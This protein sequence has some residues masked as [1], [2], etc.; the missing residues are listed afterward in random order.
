VPLQ[1]ERERLAITAA[2]AIAVQQRL[3][4]AAGIEREHLAVAAVAEKDRI[5]AAVAAHSECFAAEHKRESDT[6][7]D[8]EK[9]FIAAASGAAVI[10][11]RD[12][13]VAFSLSNSGCNER[14]RKL[15]QYSS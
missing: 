15:L 11:E 9:R 6:A 3:A 7:A 8:E 10:A 5:A 4:T 12:R 2:A 1:L 13:A 14:Q